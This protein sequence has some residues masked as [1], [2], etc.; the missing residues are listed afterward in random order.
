[1]PRKLFLEGGD[2]CPEAERSGRVTA[3]APYCGVGNFCVAVHT[4][5]PLLD[6]VEARFHLRPC[7]DVFSLPILSAFLISLQFSPETVL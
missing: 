3:H 5:K 4:P 1:M 6:Q 7:A 2:S